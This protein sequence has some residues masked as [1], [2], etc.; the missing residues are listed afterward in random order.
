MLASDLY[1]RQEPAALE[2]VTKHFQ[3]QPAMG[4]SR[5]AFRSIYWKN[6]SNDLLHVHEVL[7]M[8]VGLDTSCI[9]FSTCFNSHLQYVL[10]KRVTLMKC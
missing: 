7:G 6:I 1:Y 5:W 9:D 4:T 8:F 3:P 10:S 2:R